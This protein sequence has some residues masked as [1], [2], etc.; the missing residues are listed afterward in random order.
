MIGRMLR[1][2]SEVGHRVHSGSGGQVRAAAEARKT[3]LDHGQRAVQ[4]AKAASSASAHRLRESVSGAAA[5][6]ALAAGWRVATQRA[7][8]LKRRLLAGTVVFA[9]VYA[10]G[11]AA[12]RVLIDAIR[13]RPAPTSAPDD[14]EAGVLSRLKALG[15]TAA[16]A[17]RKLEEAAGCVT[18]AISGA[19]RERTESA[20]SSDGEHI[21]GATAVAAVGLVA[22]GLAGLASCIWK[23]SR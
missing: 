10:A 17:E 16:A 6:T 11:S 3:L 13:S 20:A 7:S 12:P 23:P 21:R 19:L 4:H 2:I 14:G 22:A 15:G 18:H 8:R 5:H 1:A 9:F